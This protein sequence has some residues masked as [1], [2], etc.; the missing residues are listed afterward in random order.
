MDAGINQ[1]PDVGGNELLHHHVNIH[2]KLV[3]A[4]TDDL[5]MERKVGLDHIMELLLVFNVVVIDCFQAVVFI[6][7]IFQLLA[8]LFCGRDNGN[9]GALPFQQVAQLLHI[10]AAFLV[11]VQRSQF[12]ENGLDGKVNN[13]GGIY[14]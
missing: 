12:T 6:Q 4:H 1:V 10:P 3:V 7:T 5:I 14:G 11:V 13:K 8:V 9:V 2:I